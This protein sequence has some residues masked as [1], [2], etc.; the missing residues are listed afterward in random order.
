MS[1]YIHCVQWLARWTKTKP[2][3]HPHNRAAILL[4]ERLKASKEGRK[5]ERRQG[6]LRRNNNSFRKGTHLSRFCHDPTHCTNGHTLHNWRGVCCLV[7]ISNFCFIKS[8]CWVTAPASNFTE[9]YA[10]GRV[11]SVN[12]KRLNKKKKKTGYDNKTVLD[13]RGVIWDS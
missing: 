3:I 8:V 9:S 12:S 5:A 1:A 11:L 4:N 10:S 13:F 2:F 6:G 7:L